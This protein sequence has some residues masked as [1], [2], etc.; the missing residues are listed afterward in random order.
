V[1]LLEAI[2]ALMLAVN[3]LFVNEKVDGRRGE[4]HAARRVGHALADPFIGTF[5]EAGGRD[6]EI[7]V[8][9]ESTR[10]GVVE[11]LFDA[12]ATHEHVVDA[13]QEVARRR[14]L[15][16]HD[17]RQPVLLRRVASETHVVKADLVAALDERR[18]VAGVVVVVVSR[19]PTTRASNRRRHL[20][21]A[22]RA[23]RSRLA[24]SIPGNRFT[25][26]TRPTFALVH[27]T[28]ADVVRRVD[29]ALTLRRRRLASLLLLDLLCLG[30]NEFVDV[31][32]VLVFRKRNLLLRCIVVDARGRSLRQEVIDALMPGR[33]DRPFLGVVLLR[34]AEHCFLN[35]I[36]RS[37]GVARHEPLQARPHA[38][39][40]ATVLPSFADLSL[41]VGWI[42]VLI[43]VG[44]LSTV[45]DVHTRVERRELV[46]HEVANVVADLLFCL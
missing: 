34:R 17:G 46:M 2:A 7:W 33:L 1:Q 12:A 28:G 44:E 40:E 9:V 22:V 19:R 42:L 45:L 3:E 32:R 43:A 11:A 26:S 13:S 6:D 29:A 23:V 25:I 16:L 24:V 4:G 27:A 41:N 10:V 21:P 18:I 38:L 14:L 31:L 37:I 39:T 30:L 5:E 8:R 36:E 15:S 20:T 35:R